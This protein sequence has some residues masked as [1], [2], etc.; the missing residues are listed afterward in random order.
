MNKSVFHIV[1]PRE[2]HLQIRS[3]PVALRV[4]FVPVAPWMHLHPPLYCI[5][6]AFSQA[7][8]VPDERYFGVKLV[9]EDSWRVFLALRSLVPMIKICTSPGAL[10]L[11]AQAVAPG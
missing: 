10:L 1:I 4:L 8:P 11:P 3:R 5:D 7:F 6:L 9:P 2:V